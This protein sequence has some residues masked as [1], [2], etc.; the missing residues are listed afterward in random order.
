MSDNPNGAAIAH[1]S[2]VIFIDISKNRGVRN[3]GTFL[4]DV[5]LRSVP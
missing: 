4:F 3:T 2:F 5:G 1:R